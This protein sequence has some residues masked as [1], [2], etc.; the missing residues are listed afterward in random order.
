MNKPSNE[1]VRVSIVTATFNSE[2]TIIQTY[3]SLCSQTH[4]NWEWLVTDD[5]SND[6]TVKV[7]EK[8]VEKDCRIKLFRNKINSGAAVSRNNSLFHVS[9]DY[10]A[11]IDSDD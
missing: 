5:C 3:H 11:F 6:N 9:G 1:D 8:L 7:L 2:K 10:I 4:D